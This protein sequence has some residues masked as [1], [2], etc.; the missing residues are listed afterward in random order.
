VD[1]EKNIENAWD[2]IESQEQPEQ[3]KLREGSKDPGKKGLEKT[4]VW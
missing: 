1:E 3:T 4:Q 2:T